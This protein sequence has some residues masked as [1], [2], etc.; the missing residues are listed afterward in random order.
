MIDINRIKE[1][2]KK[3]ARNDKKWVINKK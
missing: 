1:I 3:I 2:A